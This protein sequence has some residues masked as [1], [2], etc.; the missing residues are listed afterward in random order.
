MKIEKITDLPWKLRTW[1]R[2]SGDYRKGDP[3]ITDNDNNCWVWLGQKVEGYGRVSWEGEVTCVH[4]VVAKMVYGPRPEGYEV[5]HAE[6]C[7]KS[8]CNPAHLCYLSREEHRKKDI[9]L[10]RR[11][12]RNQSL[13]DK[14]RGG[15]LGYQK[16]GLA[17]R[18]EEN[19]HLPRY[20]HRNKDGYRAYLNIH[21]DLRPFNQ[22]RKAVYSPTR[23][24]PEEA[25]KDVPSLRN[26][27]REIKS[28]HAQAQDP[29]LSP[30]PD[31]LRGIEPR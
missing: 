26:R 20:V 12:A 18:K 1:Q 19:S 7:D 5:S 8:C 29:T 23:P 25:E 16:M 4:R 28:Q 2:R 9:E 24:T 6:G 10:H 21:P 14:K 15:F 13:E 27:I 22:G 30:S 17:C 3:R 31:S 11:G